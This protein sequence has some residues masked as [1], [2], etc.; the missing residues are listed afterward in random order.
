MPESKRVALSLRVSEHA[1]DALR[2]RA[3]REGHRYPL[4][5]AA[6]LLE[7]ALVAPASPVAG[8]DWLSDLGG[9]AR[10]FGG[11]VAV[12]GDRVTLTLEP[13]TGATAVE[14]LQGRI[15]VNHPPPD[16]VVFEVKVAS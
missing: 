13:K 11:S 7:R 8:P 3:T 14:W 10:V 5:F 15:A 9:V 16:G 12:D 2:A 6:A 1:R 4:A